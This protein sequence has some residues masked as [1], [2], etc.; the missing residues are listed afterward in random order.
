MALVDMGVVEMSYAGNPE[1]VKAFPGYE[2]FIQCAIGNKIETMLSVMS[3]T[4]GIHVGPG[5]FSLAYAA[6]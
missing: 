5:A 2:E 6:R 1:E 3:T 4:A